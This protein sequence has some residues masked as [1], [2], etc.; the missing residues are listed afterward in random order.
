MQAQEEAGS[1]WGAGEAGEGFQDESA[2][3]AIRAFSRGTRKKIYF[4]AK[5]PVGYLAFK[6]FEREH[7][8][9]V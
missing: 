8:F 6:S 1:Q 9:Q 7:G 4:A 2:P 3:T 5:C